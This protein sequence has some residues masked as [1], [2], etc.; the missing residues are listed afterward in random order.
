MINTIVC[1]K[2]G[3]FVNRIVPTTLLAILSAT[4]GCERQAP[5]PTYDTTPLQ[6][7]ST[8]SPKPQQ[9]GSEPQPSGE[10]KTREQAEARVAY[11]KKVLNAD[12][13]QPEAWTELKG[14]QRRLEPQDVWAPQTVIADEGWIYNEWAVRTFKPTMPYDRVAEDA[15]KMRARRK[16]LEALGAPVGRDGRR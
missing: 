8:T 2:K 10:I 3:D 16:G 6:K 5:L 4:L 13:G 12:G 7:E 9:A 1:S 11:L 14:L 15:G